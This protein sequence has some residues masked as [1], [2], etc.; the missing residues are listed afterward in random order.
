MTIDCQ[1]DCVGWR[2]AQIVQQEAHAH[3]A[4]GC[5][6]QMLEKDLACHVL[7]PDEIL[8]IEAALSSIRE[9]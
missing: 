8:H 1:Q 3:T 7:I 6:Q 4:V 2:R 5:A 9:G